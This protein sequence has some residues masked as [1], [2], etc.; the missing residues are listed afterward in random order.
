MAISAGCTGMARNKKFASHSD[1]QPAMSI[2]LQLVIHPSTNQAQLVT[3]T[4]HAS[5][6][7]KKKLFSLYTLAGKLIFIQHSILT[8]R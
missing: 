1:A 6:N 2:E 8:M 5:I 7:R 4:Q 3:S